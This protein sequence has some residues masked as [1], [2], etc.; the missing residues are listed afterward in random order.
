MASALRSIR[1]AVYLHL[2]VL[3]NMCCDIRPPSKAYA[4]SARR[5][6]QPTILQDLDVAFTVPHASQRLYEPQM[7]A[8]GLL[9][10]MIGLEC[11]DG[12]QQLLRLLLEHC[13]S[14]SSAKF[15]RNMPYTVGASGNVAVPHICIC[16]DTAHITMTDTRCAN[17]TNSGF[18]R[19]CPE[20]HFPIPNRWTQHVR[21][22]VLF[23]V[24]VAVDQMRIT[25][26]RLQASVL[27]EP[28]R[29]TIEFRL[30]RHKIELPLDRRPRIERQLPKHPRCPTQASRVLLVRTW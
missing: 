3:A 18:L 23:W 26:D 6:E 30:Y 10:H 21:F 7:A 2:T 27:A 11:P 28:V 9:D 20:G 5:A 15:S 1:Q 24:C 25:I 13:E 16:R 14:T 29:R 17:C 8:R 12:F 19:R 22:G 4:S